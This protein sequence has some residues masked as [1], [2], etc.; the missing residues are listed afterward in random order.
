MYA[1]GVSRPEPRRNL[2]FTVDH[3]IVMYESTYEANDN[4]WG[5]CRREG[6]WLWPCYRARP[7]YNRTRSEKSKT[8]YKRA[9]E[10]H[11]G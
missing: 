4:N 6:R 11:E 10:T 3:V 1:H 5:D 2:D 8:E 9:H 7:G